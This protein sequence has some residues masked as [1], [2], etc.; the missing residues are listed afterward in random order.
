MSIDSV[1]FKSYEEPTFPAALAPTRV[2]DGYATVAFT[3]DPAGAI[4]DAVIIAASHPSFGES[5][6]SAVK[7]WRLA[8]DA[9]KKKPPSPQLPEGKF[10]AT[11]SAAT[12]RSFR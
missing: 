1:S 6:L 8:N 12:A 5:V 7:N 9:G 10:S 11:N 3:A 4:K 2:M